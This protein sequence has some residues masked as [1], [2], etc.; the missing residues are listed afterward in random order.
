MTQH[1]VVDRIACDGAGLCAHLAPDVIALDPW[2]Y[3]VISASSTPTAHEPIDERIDKPI[4]EQWVR[5][6]RKA[7]KGCP[8]RALHIVDTTAASA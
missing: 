2:G 5:Q 7:V 1:L 3:P 4:D 6:V 8:R